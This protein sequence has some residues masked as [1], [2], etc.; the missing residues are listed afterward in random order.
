M[1]RV[2]RFVHISRVC[3]QPFRA[4]LTLPPE[5]LTELRPFDPQV[6]PCFRGCNHLRVLKHDEF[7]NA[8]IILL[9]PTKNCVKTTRYSSSLSPQCCSARFRTWIS[10][11][12]MKFP[13]NEVFLV[14]ISSNL[15]GSN[16]I[17]PKSVEIKLVPIFY[18]AIAIFRIW[19]FFNSSPHHTQLVQQFELIWNLKIRWKKEKSR[20]LIKDLR[21]ED[22]SVLVGEVSSARGRESFVSEKTN[23]TIKPLE[24]KLFCPLVSDLFQHFI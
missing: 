20:E 24:T 23:S 5:V 17:L 18:K 9:P 16:W 3:K 8:V 1:H 10:G 7:S 2:S 21:C 19:V 6:Q 4:V 11:I 12:E 22:W 14:R 15:E 13:W